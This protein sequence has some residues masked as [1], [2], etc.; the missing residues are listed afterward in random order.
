MNLR[1]KISALNSN[2]CALFSSGYG[3]SGRIAGGS[4]SCSWKRTVSAILRVMGM[5]HEQQFQR[6]H[7]VLNRTCG[8]VIKPIAVAAACERIAP[9]RGASNGLMTRLSGAGQANCS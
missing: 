2:V 1:S 5:Q 6:Y 7:R 3:I 9:S 4:N 8:Q